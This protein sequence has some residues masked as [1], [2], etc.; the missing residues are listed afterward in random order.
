MEKIWRQNKEAI[1]FMLYNTN[2]K[3]LFLGDYIT[4]LVFK[5]FCF[6]R[7]EIKLPHTYHQW[8]FFQF[9]DVAPKLVINHTRI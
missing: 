7:F 1:F 4:L 2:L 6:W 8:S 5:I 9:F 3:C